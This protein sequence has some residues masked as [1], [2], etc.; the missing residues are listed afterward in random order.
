MISRFSKWYY[1]KPDRTGLVVGFHYDELGVLIQIFFVHNQSFEKKY[2]NFNAIIDLFDE[3]SIEVD[4]ITT[5]K[6]RYKKVEN[7]NKY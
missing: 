5:I 1:S 6:C 7:F 2:E 3:Y 4:S